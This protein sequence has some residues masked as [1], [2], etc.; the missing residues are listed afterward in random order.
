MEFLKD[1]HYTGWEQSNYETLE[2]LNK[3]MTAGSGVDASQFT[4]GRA[5]SIESLDQ[6][7]VNILFNQDEAVVFQ[8]LKKQPIKSPVHQWDQRTEVGADD[9]AWVD[10]G[11]ASQATDQTIARKFLTVS[12]LQTYRAVTLQATIANMIE[13]AVALEKDAGT[14]WL[15]RNVEKSL[16]YGNQTFIAEQPT[17]LKYG[18]PSTNILDLRGADATS[19]QYEDKINE[20]AR[21]I[22]QS[23]GRGDH[24]IT[25]PIVMQD[26]Q[27]LLRDRIR[28]EAGENGLGSRVFTKYPTP[29]GSPTLKEDIFLLEGTTPVASSLTSLRPSKPTITAAQAALGGGLVSLWDASNVG[30][31]YYQVVAVNQYG[32][33]VASD[34]VTATPTVG[35]EV[36]ITI[37][38][39]ATPGTAFKVYRSQK[40]ASDSTDCRY[41]FTVARTGALMTFTDTNADLPGCSDAYL[42]TIDPAYNAIEWAQ[43]LPM[44]KFDLY[45]TAS[46]VVPFLMLLFGGLAIKK[47]VQH[48][49][50]KNIAPS[51]L[52]WY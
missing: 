35:T 8:L 10:E 32:D 6:T 27:K 30:Q 15:I 39:E 2:M 5:L 9:G 31:Y 38:V 18:I 7:L 3:A 36:L 1:I 44:M 43:F 51:S 24:L 50:I 28:F 34:A 48:I 26:T 17:G 52:N 12:Y 42:L 25:S 49:R 14:R 16:L 11:A 29:F 41:A 4:G 37:T 19:S 21:V 45:P 46:A 13:D 23:F 40:G 47:P 20:G 33:S 22:R